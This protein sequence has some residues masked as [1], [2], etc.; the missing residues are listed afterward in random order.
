[1]VTG[2]LPI[3]VNGVQDALP[4]HDAVVV[5]ALC[6]PPL[7]VPYKRLPDVKLVWPVPPFPTGNVPVTSA[8]RETVA[9]E[10]M[11]AFESERTN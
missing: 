7:P 1:M 4:L 11:Y 3:T 2:E 6:N 5:A 9:H 8:V 10:A